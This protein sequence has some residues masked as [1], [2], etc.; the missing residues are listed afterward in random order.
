MA[1]TVGSGV[2]GVVSGGDAAS[3][4]PHASPRA[5]SP[6]SMLEQQLGL[7][8]TAQPPSGVSSDATSQYA[9]YTSLQSGMSS[10]TSADRMWHRHCMHALT[11]TA[12][13]VRM[14]VRGA[15]LVAPLQ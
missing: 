7:Y 13:F 10:A 14:N 15:R 9:M 3:S 4:A 8:S 12:R 6:L 11:H 5:S 1:D 2:G